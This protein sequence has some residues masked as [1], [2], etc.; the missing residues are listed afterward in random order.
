MASEGT[1]WY[2]AGK[3]IQR[4]QASPHVPDAWGVWQNGLGC[5]CQ[6]QLLHWASLVWQSLGQGWGSY[7]VGGISW[8][9][10]SKIPSQKL[11][12]FLQLGSEVPEHHFCP[13]LKFVN[14]SLMSAQVQRQGIGPHLSMGE[15][16]KN[17]CSSLVYCSIIPCDWD[18][19]GNCREQVDQGKAMEFMRICMVK[20]H[21]GTTLRED[22]LSI[23]TECIKSEEGHGDSPRIHLP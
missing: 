20:V 5:R 13:K 12:G 8:N 23:C 15:I 19:E 17:L 14:T 16:A 3:W 10:H 4:L 9:K 11:Q 22:T 7:V 1:H 18:Q 6:P 2:L 21:M